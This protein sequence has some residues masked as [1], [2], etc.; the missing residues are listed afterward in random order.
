MRK[1]KKSFKA[2]RKKS[3][4]WGKDS[5]F[6]RVGEPLPD[7]SGKVDWRSDYYKIRHDHGHPFI[8]HE[9]VKFW[10]ENFL[11]DAHGDE[12]RK[13]YLDGEMTCTNISKYVIELSNDL[14]QARLY[15]VGR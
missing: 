1:S 3:K 5:S 6:F 8:E 7:G 2:G 10:L 15:L 12:K 14:K 11:E 9:G 13:G 4:V